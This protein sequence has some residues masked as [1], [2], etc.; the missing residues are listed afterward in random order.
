LNTGS[1]WTAWRTVIHSGNIGSQSVSA[2]TNATNATY[3]RYVYNDA[4]Y[5]G[6]AGYVEP[7]SLR[8]YYSSTS[9]ACSGVSARATRANGN[10]YIDDN[11][12]NSV[13]GVYSASR[14]Q[15]V[16]AMGDS[17]KLPADGSAATGLYG[18]AWSHPNAGGIA[19]NLD[20]HGALVVINGG[21]G[22]ALST[23]IV[24]AGNI[25]AYSD[26]RLKTNWKDL[27]NDFVSKLATVKTGTFDRIDRGL[28]TQVGVS[29][30]S[31]REVL[32]EAVKE[33]DDEDKTLSVHYG[34]AA[35][36]AAVMLA[37]ELVSLKDL[38]KELRAEIDELKKS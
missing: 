38:V 28:G 14:F 19:A 6:T 10:L 34:N 9:G 26:E 29:A 8:V 2:A 23:S 17:Y 30:Q 25:T 33:A 37:R 11:Y 16:F 18:I 13:V 20:S 36:A 24:A 15:G 22:C 12:G 7:S 32:P 35:L 1:G 4:T 31:L 3:G 5:G 21:F 27:G